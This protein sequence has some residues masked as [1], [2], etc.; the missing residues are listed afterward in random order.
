MAGAL[1]CRLP[2]V[3]SYLRPELLLPPRPTLALSAVGPFGGDGDGGDGGDGSGGDG[4]GGRGGRIGTSGRYTSQAQK[5]NV[6]W[7]YG[8]RKESNT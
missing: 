4:R 8:T 7:S 3:L 1:E 5:R 6:V 2:L